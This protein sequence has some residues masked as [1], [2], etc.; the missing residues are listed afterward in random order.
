M[1][2]KPNRSQNA[3]QIR[4]S[5]CLS[6]SN[7]KSTW[8][9]VIPMTIQQDLISQSHFGNYQD[10]RSEPKVYMCG[11]QGIH[12]WNPRYT[13]IEPKVYMCGTQGIHAWNPR[14]TCIEP[15]VYMCG[16]KVYMCETQGIHGTQGINVW[17]PRYI[18]TCVEPNACMCGT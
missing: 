7:F 18:Y 4:S 11:T 17:N 13:C 1:S 16:P 12:A 15:K 8:S 2:S 10:V 14:Y 5:T 6:S 9:W 3:H